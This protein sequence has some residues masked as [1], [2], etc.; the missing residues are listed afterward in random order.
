[1]SQKFFSKKNQCIILAQ[2]AIN[3]L[4]LLIVSDAEFAHCLIISR[5]ER[6]EGSFRSSDILFQELIKIFV[7]EYIQ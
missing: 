4:V 1:M 5:V 7:M 3:W 6:L 2:D